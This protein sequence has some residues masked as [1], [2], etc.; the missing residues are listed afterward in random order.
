MSA[1]EVVIFTGDSKRVNK[2]NFYH[3][4][5]ETQRR[6]ARCGSGVSSQPNLQSRPGVKI[7][8]SF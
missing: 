2:V 1:N 8:V 4:H 7:V 5:T 6:F 3:E